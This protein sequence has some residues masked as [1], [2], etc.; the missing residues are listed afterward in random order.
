MYEVNAV[1]IENR[2]RARNNESKRINYGKGKL[3][4]PRLLTNTHKNKR[5]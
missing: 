2:M 4:D 3:I 1:N 5:K